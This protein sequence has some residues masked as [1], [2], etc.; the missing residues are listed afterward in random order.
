MFFASFHVQVVARGIVNEVVLCQRHGVDHL[1]PWYRLSIKHLQHMGLTLR[2]LASDTRGA[3]LF[4]AVAQAMRALESRHWL[5]VIVA[6]ISLG[7]PLCLVGAFVAGIMS[8]MAGALRARRVASVAREEILEIAW[9]RSRQSC[10]TTM[11]CC[12]QCKVCS[13]PLATAR[14]AW[15]EH[16]A[17]HRRGFLQVPGG[18]VGSRMRAFTDLPGDLQLRVLSWI[19]PSLEAFLEG[20]RRHGVARAGGLELFVCGHV[21]HERC[22]D[23]CLQT[24]HA[25]PVC[26]AA[27][28]RIATPS[29][30]DV[31][32]WV[33]LQRS[34]RVAVRAASLLEIGAPF[35][36][37]APYF[38]VPA[39]T[40][41]LNWKLFPTFRFGGKDDLFTYRV[42]MGQPWSS[43]HISLR[44]HV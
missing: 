43:C 4:R 27:D 31:V 20:H 23:R 40:L 2:E 32:S 29:S 25:C 28:P 6:R 26:Q 3:A 5:R 39:L 35:L 21:F 14:R 15:V 41:I 8:D 36:S 17:L 1:I 42:S 16:L 18:E 22:G 9:M 11:P 38:A 37:I 19:G 33:V 12:W 24:R 13:K 10:A 30:F 44:Q 7:V 34:L